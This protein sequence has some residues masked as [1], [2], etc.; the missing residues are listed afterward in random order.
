MTTEV[1]VENPRITV[2]MERKV[3][4]GDF[5]SITG[6]IYIQVPTTFD[7]T[8]AEN[9]EKAKF[10]FADAH[11]SLC[12]QLGLTYDVVE[13]VVVERL[14]RTL[15]AQVSSNGDEQQ[16]VESAGARVNTVPQGGSGTV[17]TN[18]DEAIADLLANP[19]GWF[20]NRTTKTGRQPDFKRK[21]AAAPGEK[22][23]P[24][25]YLDKLTKVGVT[26][27]EASAF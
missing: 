10:A 9:I 20:D 12:E 24:S 18:S 23:P 11:A 17:P 27:P 5:E 19:K 2:G 15:G 21:G 3:N 13:G 8:S 6:S 26:P 4:L 7:A 14:A 22:Y 25:L 1:L 16:A